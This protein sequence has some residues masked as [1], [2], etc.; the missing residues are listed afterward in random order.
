[1]IA[2]ELINHMIPPLKITD[3]ADK[4]IVWMEEL[5]C[6]FLPV[7]ESGKFLG[8][9]SE[10]IIMEEND[11]DKPMSE[12]KLIGKDCYVTEETHFYDILKKASDFNVQT[13]AV[14]DSM[15]VYTGV[16][17]V[18]DCINVFVQSAAIQ[19]YGGILVLSMDLRDYSLAEIARLVEENNLKILNSNVRIDPADPGKIKLTLKINSTELNRVIATL[20]R[21]DYKIIAKFQDNEISEPERD[22]IDL[23]F[24]YLEI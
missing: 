7:T 13:V 5:R 14:L 10:D 9:I 22:R 4:A 19:M 18:Q 11:I 16:I 20:E 1:M 24:R 8:L 15:G 12:F 21:F 17:T 3:D 2:K 23:L 6:N